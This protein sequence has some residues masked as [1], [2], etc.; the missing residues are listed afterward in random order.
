[1]ILLFLQPRKKGKKDKIICVVNKYSEF[2]FLGSQVVSYQGRYVI[3]Q[4]IPETF[5]NIL[6]KSHKELKNSYST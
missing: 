6:V 1:M 4:Y 5:Y 2:K 3:Y